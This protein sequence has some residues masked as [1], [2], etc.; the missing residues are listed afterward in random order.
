MGN[1]VERFETKYQYCEYVANKRGVPVEQVLEE[2]NSAS[3]DS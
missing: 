3:E 1:Q 2:Y